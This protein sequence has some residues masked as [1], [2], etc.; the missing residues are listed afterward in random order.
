MQLNLVIAICKIVGSSMI[1]MILDPDQKHDNYQISFLFSVQALKLR[2]STSR[3]HK[4]VSIDNFTL[5]K[6]I[7]LE[8]NDPLSHSQP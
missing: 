3:D 1:S 7:W 8:A 5:T 6:I 2:L 4:L